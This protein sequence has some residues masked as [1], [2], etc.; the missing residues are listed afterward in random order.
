[1]G[2]V[3]QDLLTLKDLKTPR[4]QVIDRSQSVL[5]G[6]SDASVDAY[7]AC[8]YLYTNLGNI[9]LVTS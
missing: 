3:F 5:V 4:S 1:M 2:S 7:S 9:S 6:F 8:I